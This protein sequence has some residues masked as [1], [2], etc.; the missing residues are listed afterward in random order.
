MDLTEYRNRQSEQLR[1]GDLLNLVPEKG[2]SALDVGARDGYI[3]ALLT[4]SF[5]T[6]TA[7]DLSKP[8]VKHDQIHCVR[9]DVTS[10]GFPDDS[11]DLVLCTE[12]LEHLPQDCVTKACLELA[13]VAKTHLLV[14]VPYKQDIRV[15]RT[16][17]GACGKKNPPWGHINTFD[18][19]RL[20]FLFPDLVVK[21]I[22]YIG[23]N[24]AGTNFLSAFLMDLA[25]N[26]YGTYADGEVC[27]HCGAELEGPSPR[28][29]VQKVFTKCAFYLDEMIKVVRSPTA[30]ANWIHMLF[31]KK[32]RE[33]PRRSRASAST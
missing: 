10:L 23:Q 13:R 29:V 3:S 14:G 32:P 30:H 21:D 12:V 18:E 5:Q 24:D 7:L 20:R 1:I 9:G 22:S 2:D 11:F 16:T 28:N 8:D 4:K 33:T 26:P 6:V 17:C 19:E 15:G 27:G 25:G 31:L